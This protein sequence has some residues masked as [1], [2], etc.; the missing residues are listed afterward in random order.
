M[1]QPGVAA[2][3]LAGRLGR[4]VVRERGGVRYLEL[5]ARNL[6]NRCNSPRVPFRWTVNPYRGCAL[7]CRYCYASYTHEY[8]GRDAAA[9]F[10]STIYAKNGGL[11]EARRALQ[12]AARRRELVALG[13]ATDPYQPAEAHFQVTRRFLELAAGVRGLRLAIT[14]KAALVLRDVELL[15]RLHARGSLSVNISLVS[16]DAE[17]LRRLEPWAPP[18]EVRLEV[19]RRLVAAG[20]RVSH[21]LAPMLPGLTDA[22]AD[23]DAL[24]TAVK[25][26]GVRRSWANLLFLRSPT[27]ERFMAWL[28]EAAPERVA[29]YE[30]A[31]GRGAYLDR[32]TRER[33]MARVDRLRVRHGLAGVRALDEW[34]PGGPAQQLPL[35]TDP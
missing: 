35:W 17:L 26:A 4:E 9:E 32:A 21:S 25:R 2:P 31:Y 1:V 24:L 11:E 6:V 10:A 13:T 19:M 27:R 5:R 7:G 30:R 3:S 16:L 14:T 15:Q 20:L 29:A 33:L 34:A 28:A 22:E 18:P 12:T 8:L 23:L